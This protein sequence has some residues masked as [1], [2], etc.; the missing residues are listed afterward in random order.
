MTA[1]FKRLRWALALAILQGTIFATVGLLEH[2]K[3]V[4][5]GRFCG[6]NRVEFFGC[7]PLPREPLTKEERQRLAFVECWSPRHVTLVF[8]TNLPVFF[9]WATMKTLT[10]KQHVDEVFVF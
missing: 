9:C 7:T 1:L 5:Y 10:A 6:L 8:L 3:G 4:T 2:G